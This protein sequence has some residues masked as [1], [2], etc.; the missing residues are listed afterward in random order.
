MAPANELEA[1]LEGRSAA[2]KRDPETVALISAARALRDAAAADR[3]ML[4]GG[5]DRALLRLR[6]TLRAQRTN[7][8]PIHTRMRTAPHRPLFRPAFAR[9]AM[10]AA[11]LIVGAA[12]VAG[13]G[14]LGDPMRAAARTLGLSGVTSTKVEAPMG[15][16]TVDPLASGKAKGEQR[17]DRTRFAVEVEDASTSGPHSVRITRGGVEIALSPVTVDVNALGFGELDLNTIDGAT[18]V[19]VALAGDLVEVMNPNG[20]VILSGTLQ[21]K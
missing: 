13:P 1:A 10:A 2:P 7:I 12:L 19:P 18:N 9:V 11:V 6:S 21:A 8:T 14:S 3:A 20:D 4:F 16:S 5:E 17:T 15:A